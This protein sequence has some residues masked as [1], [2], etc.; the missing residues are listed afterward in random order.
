MNIRRWIDS[1]HPLRQQNVEGT[2]I[3][4]SYRAQDR[5]GFSLFSKDWFFKNDFLFKLSFRIDISRTVTIRVAAS[6]DFS[7]K[8]SIRAVASF[9]TIRSYEFARGEGPEWPAG[10]FIHLSWLTRPISLP[11]PFFHPFT[12]LCFIVRYFFYSRKNPDC[13]PVRS[14]RI[15]RP[16]SLVYDPRVPESI[17]GLPHT[18]SLFVPYGPYETMIKRARARR[19]VGRR[20]E[21]LRCLE[22][23]DSMMVT[24]R[25]ERRCFSRL[26]YLKRDPQARRIIND[27]EGNPLG[28]AYFSFSTV[29]LFVPSDFV[30]VLILRNCSTLS[31]RT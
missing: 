26:A 13:R 25:H 20:I 16:R 9:R 4:Q 14:P 3:P 10:R 17:L 7:R 30:F 1:F 8:D 12:S 6:L 11:L 28:P 2:K 29:H 5:T 18:C 15:L 23:A 19:R 24:F 22:V 31:S 21:R 27:P